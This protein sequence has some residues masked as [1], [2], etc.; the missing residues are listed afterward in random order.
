MVVHNRSND[1]I[2]GA[3]GANAVHFSFL[4]EVMAAWIDVPVGRYWQVSSNFHSY[5][6]TLEKHGYVIKN[7]PGFDAYSL[8]EV[9]PYPIV[10]EI[11]QWFQD[12]DMFMSYGPSMNLK[13]P[14]FKRVAG[15]MYQ[16]WFAWKNKDDP[17]HLEK[18]I[19]FAD[20][21]HATDWRKACVEWLE[22]RIK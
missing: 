2:W 11:D 5:H 20:Q 7:A 8:G 9:E 3:Y 10:R 12:L 18:A 22:R 1:M 16:S 14:F 21:I 13:E 6:N 17:N 19:G 4:Q 15:P